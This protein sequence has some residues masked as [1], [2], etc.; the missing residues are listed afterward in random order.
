MIF[1]DFFDKEENKEM[2][3]KL[4]GASFSKTNELHE[5]VFKKL[6]DAKYR[7]QLMGELFVDD[8]KARER[9]AR[10]K[11]DEG[12]VF[13]VSAAMLIDIQKLLG[14]NP[15]KVDRVKAQAAL[16]IIATYLEEHDKLRAEAGSE[17]GN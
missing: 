15:F 13:A 17:E 2:A 14:I 12:P 6:E 4:T 11:T 16:M 7:D 9:L 1:K 3:S 10:G 5:A 8:D